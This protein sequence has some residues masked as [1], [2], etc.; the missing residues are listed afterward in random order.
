M[1]NKILSFTAALFIA[2]A[3]LT[4]CQS[5]SDKVKNAKDNVN[6]A[7]MQ[8]KETQQELDQAL[9]DSIQ[10][11][12][13]ESNLIIAANEK[14][15]ATFKQKIENGS[16]A[17]KAKYEKEVDALEQ[18]N[19]D[20]KTKLDKYSDEGATKWQDFKSG[21]KSDMDSLGKSISDFTAKM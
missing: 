12:K 17:T 9:Q 11:F 6:D 1:R 20:L 13:S 10:Q 8:V 18:E 19:S 4:S 14:K 2:G 7:E 16:K 3:L 21:F 15:I 5:S